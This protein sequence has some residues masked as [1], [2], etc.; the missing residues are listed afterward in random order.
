MPDID[1]L[2]I[3]HDHWGHLDYPT[4]MGLK[5]KIKAIV[6]GL[7]VGAHFRRW[8]FS[9]SVIHEADWGE[10]LH[11]GSIVHIHVT[12]ASPY[13]GRSLTRNKSL[14]AGFLLESPSRKSSSAVTAAMDPILLK[15]ADTPWRY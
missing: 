9:E 14:W 1:C 4:V 13:S 12:T 6:C 15:S 2:L 7:G 11:F 10:V 3:S 8:G 5:S